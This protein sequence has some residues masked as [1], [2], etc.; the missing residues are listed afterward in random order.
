MITLLVFFFFFSSRRRHTRL[1]CDWSSACALPISRRLELPAGG[2]MAE[3]DQVLSALRFAR[4]LEQALC[5]DGVGRDGTARLRRIEVT[6][7][8]RVHEAEGRRRTCGPRQLRLGL[9]QIDLAQ[10]EPGVVV[11]VVLGDVS[12][13]G[14]PLVDANTLAFARLRHVA[15][16]GREYQPRGSLGAPRSFAHRRARQYI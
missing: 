8:Q 7:P 4:E 1:T 9:D 13:I 10:P 11:A 3:A 12:G 16:R 14:G 5:E 2:V 6:S 15:D